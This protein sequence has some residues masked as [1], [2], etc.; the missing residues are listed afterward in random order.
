MTYFAVTNLQSFLAILERLAQVFEMEEFEL[1]RI[2][3]SEEKDICVK[4]TDAA[5]AWGYRVKEDQSAAKKSKQR[6]RLLIEDFNDPIISS[7]NLDLK[8]DDTI[9]VVGQ[10]GSGKTTLLFSIMEETRIIAGNRQISGTIA[11][12]E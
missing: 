8:H 7:V 1:T 5:F 4:F 11:Y 10:V 3:N 2:T 9:V 6:A 12:V